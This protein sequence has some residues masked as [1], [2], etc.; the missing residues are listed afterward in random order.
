[1][2]ALSVLY[3]VFPILAVSFCRTLEVMFTARRW[4][5]RHQETTTKENSGL[6]NILFRLS[7]MNTKAFLIAGGTGFLAVLL[8]TAV[9]FVGGLWAERIWATVFMAYSSCALINIIRAVTIKGY[10][11]GLVTSLIFL[12]LIA[13]TSY[14]LFLAWPW[15]EM[16]LFGVIGIALAVAGLYS[17]QSC[18]TDPLP[19]I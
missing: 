18:A 7:G 9:L 5:L 17:I 19:R 4:A 16:L 10:V 1:M 14:S 2:S 12:P 11:P 8:A 6:M 15:W 3:I 13:L